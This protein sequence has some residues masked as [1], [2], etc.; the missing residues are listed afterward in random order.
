MKL[1]GRQVT[2]HPKPL[3][4]GD[5]YKELKNRILVELVTTTEVI[6]LD[7]FVLVSMSRVTGSSVRSFF[8]SGVDG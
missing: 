1:N 8:R 7:M 2:S 4:Q 5:V 3:K 6:D